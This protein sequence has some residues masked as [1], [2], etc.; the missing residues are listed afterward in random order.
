MNGKRHG[1]LAEWALKDV[2]L[3]SNAS[4]ADIGCGGGANV[5]RILDKFPDS[6]VSGVDF[7]PVA[8]NMALRVNKEA[9]A[10]GRCKIVG[11]NAKLLPLLKEN[12][13]LI[14]A[15]ETVYYW[16]SF[17]E[18]LAEIHR[19]LKSG[20]KVVIAN[21]T[22]G[23]DPEGHKSANFK[24]C[25][26]HPKWRGHHLQVK[27]GNLLNNEAH[28]R[29]IDLLCATASPHNIASI[30]SLQQLGYRA[31]HTVQKYGFERTVFFYF[32]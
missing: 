18:C 30:R 20:G 17:S 23:I 4:I 26:V 19:V 1:A 3:N 21:E 25:L 22:D 15:F 8:I 13:D 11:G 16:P 6:K 12:Y 31:D 14:T 27:L 24:I 9:I 28:Q 32:N 29:G 5:A 7:S 2:Q 10:A